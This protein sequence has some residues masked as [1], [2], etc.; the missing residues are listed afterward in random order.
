MA[1]TVAGWP[2]VAECF[3]ALCIGVDTPF[4][5]KA[6]LL[7]KYGE[8]Q[9][10]AE[11]KVKAR[12]YLTAHTFAGDYAVASF[13]K[14]NKDLPLKVDREGAAITSFNASEERCKMTNL[15]VETYL[16]GDLKIA[17]DVNEVI[18]LA[19]RKISRLL[20]VSPEINTGP[21]CWGP[22]ATFDMSR[23]KAYPDSKIVTLPFTVTGSAWKHAAAM[24]KSDL[25]WKEAIV[26]ANPGYKGM[27][28]K[29]VPGGRFDTVSKTVLTD[30]G[31]LV[32]PRLNTVLQKR[33]GSQLRGLLKRVGVDLDDQTRNQALA[34]FARSWDLATLDLEAASDTVS[35][36]VV[37]LLIPPVWYDI[38]DDLRSK[39]Y[40]KKDKTWQRLEKFSS[41]GNGFTFELESLIFWALA[42][43]ASEL[44]YRTTVGVFGDDIILHRDAAPLLIRTFDFLG[45]SVN[46]EKSFVEGEFFE[47][48]GKHYF[49]DFDVTPAY[50]KCT[51]V[52]GVEAAKMGN[53]LLRLASRLGLDVSLDKR[54]RPAWNNWFRHWKVEPIRC[55]PFIGEGDGYWE[56]PVSYY[57]DRS[58]VDPWG[59]WCQV[60]CYSPAKQEIPAI[61]EAMYAI[62]LMQC[63][64]QD[65]K[66][67]EDLGGSP[68][69]VGI[70]RALERL[71]EYRDSAVS[72]TGTVSRPRYSSSLA[73]IG[74]VATRVKTPYVTKHRPVRYGLRSTSLDW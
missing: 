45:F 10:L 37:E 40:Q 2:A 5:L 55:G 39:W 12:Q 67:G 70:K 22:G 41:M 18:H 7:V 73:D 71:H 9:Q 60:A 44:S 26:A 64:P 42:S 21:Y 25:H 46:M 56:T 17:S 36:K 27:I 62:W 49:G 54:V 68:D 65:T 50:Q 53:R 34:S 72:I 3:R 32:E 58:R 15:R 14:K 28:F 48:C 30:R 38:L 23:R 63:Q 52:D 61:D 51:P 33:V 4:S 74:K 1:H 6:A 59:L 57:A 66:P 19:S 31:I 47:S 43:A 13:L 11:L 16:R 24:I 20:A 69:P 8:M 35:R 29:V